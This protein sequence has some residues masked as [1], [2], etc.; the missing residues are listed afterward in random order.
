VL[1]MVTGFVTACYATGHEVVTCVMCY[2]IQ[3]KRGNIHTLYTVI[4]VRCITLYSNGPNS[5]V[6][7][8]NIVLLRCVTWYDMIID[9][10]SV[11]P[12]W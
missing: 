2:L 8:P 4:A 3:Y 11:L 6:F 1:G 5:A 12:E 7:L 10:C 9:Q